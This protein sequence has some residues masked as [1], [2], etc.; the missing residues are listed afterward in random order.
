MRLILPLT[1]IIFLSACADAAKPALD[2]TLP[3]LDGK[4]DG[5]AFGEGAAL[6][7]GAVVE[8][9]LGAG[10]QRVA[11][12][13]S[14]AG[15]ASVSL[16]VLAAGT[17]AGLDT[18]LHVIGPLASDGSCPSLARA[19]DD[20]GGDGA[21]SRLAGL[22]L[23]AGDWLVVIGTFGDAG[24][25]TYRLEA[26]CDSGAC[27]AP[28]ACEAAD[29]IAACV[30]GAEEGL[31]VGGD[32]GPV[33]DLRSMDAFDVHAA[34]AG[35][36]G[37]ACAV[38]TWADAAAEACVFGVRYPDLEALAEGV[39]VIG[40][41]VV[42]GP[43]GLDEVAE[44]QLLE[45]VKSTAYDDVRSL[46]EAFEAIDD[47]RANRTELWDASN[48]AAY[49]AWE[50]GAGDNSFGAIFAFGTTRAVATI[51]DGDFATCDVTTGPSRRWCT[52]EAGCDAG[53]VCLGVVDGLGLCAPTDAA[54]P[55]GAGRQCAP[56]L[57]DFGCGL[58]TG[59]VC[60]SAG[61]DFAGTCVE[62]RHRFVAGPVIDPEVPAGATT[63]VPLVVRGVGPVVTGVRL[64]FVL[65]HPRLNELRVE[66]VAPDGRKATVFDGPT[67]SDL[68]AHGE[69]VVDGF[70]DR[71]VTGGQA[72]GRWLLRFT[73]GGTGEGGSLLEATLTVTAGP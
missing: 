3:G 70:G 5:A 66:L 41:T 30:A 19:S 37:A 22:A 26:R 17:T 18:T 48:G 36:D 42:E 61:A 39:V 34:C 14:L 11:H 69:L 44:G 60:G 20:D 33:Y 10:V 24:A 15:P 9:T 2:P 12:R 52:P 35:P 63:E 32:E 72:A 7:P 50:V 38:S 6:T 57:E 47:G 46:E 62:A 4:A 56:W 29:A 27:L 13:L 58:G 8:G 21:L 68:P 53:L 25:G 65:G 51:V 40:R 59:L 45:A 64:S 43:D 23:D 1:A 54:R 28:P 55:E 73:D 31:P 16:E 49:T 67:A 71:P